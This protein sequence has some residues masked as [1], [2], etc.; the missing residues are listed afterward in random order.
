MPFL[1]RRRFLERS[2][3][4]VGSFSFL[5]L[6][7]GKRA[8]ASFPFG[9]QTTLSTPP[10][11]EG[12]VFHDRNGTGVRDTDE[13][14]IKGVCVSNG[15]DIVRTDDRGHYRIPVVED[16][17]LFVI[18]PSG[19]MTPTDTENLPRFYYIHKPSGSPKLK[20]PGISPTGP[21]PTSVD[22]PLR[23]RSE[24]DKFRIVLF[25]DPQPRNQQEIDFIAHDVV[26][27]LIG[28]DAAFGLSLGD[29][30]FNDLSLF[31]SLNKTVATIGLPWYN[32]LGNHDTNQDAADDTYSAETFKRVYGPSYYAFDY[33]KVHFLIL[34]N[35]V[36]EGA[37]KKT[38]YGGLGE[39]QMA[40]VKNDLALVPKD[41]L[42]VVSMHIPITSMKDREALYRLLEDRPHAFS[43]SA[44]THYQKVLHL[45]EKDGWKGKDPHHHLNHA[46]VCGSWWAGATD[47]RGIP[48]A[49]MS[50]GAPNGYS[51]IEFDGNKYKIEFKPA[52]RPADTQMS[53]YTPEV[54]AAAD[55]SKTEVVVNV[56]A[57]SSRSKVEMRIGKDALWLPL[58]H[59]VREDP[60][61]LSLK[62]IETSEKLPTGRKLPVAG[63]CQHLW[64]AK[65]PGTLTPGTH[66]IEIR[67][68]DMYGHNYTAQRILRVS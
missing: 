66:R 60:Y 47:E 53:I 23:K 36:W 52:R 54:I 12:F 8:N 57:G 7:F 43:I 44:H 14:G 15:R 37:A 32:V 65:L 11:A 50:D 29:E 42:V 58:E 10:F 6:L 1:D 63:K 4:L 24:P 67:T 17:I 38:Y 40:F 55:T 28:V 34:D 48:H 21:L 9:K 64:A 25:G 5:P 51:F 39:K 45:E 41:H 31:D 18:K 49:T 61:F 26:E 59:T 33:G 30:M 46:T 68:T 22:F 27:E 56:Y 2:A 13:D 35:V 19:W 62:E 3:A 16:D 20:F